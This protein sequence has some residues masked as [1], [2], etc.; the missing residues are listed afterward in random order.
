MSVWPVAPLPRYDTTSSWADVQAGVPGGIGIG[1]LGDGLGACGNAPV[2]ARGS[3]GTYAGVP[4]A[5]APPRPVA[6]HAVERTTTAS[7]APQPRRISKT[8]RRSA[9]NGYAACEPLAPARPIPARITHPWRQR[10]A[11]RYG[12]SIAP[13]EAEPRAASSVPDSPD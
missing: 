8:K 5:V 13:S 7:N 4:L 10:G 2:R 3:H 9:A 1:G 11:K 6:A 12:F